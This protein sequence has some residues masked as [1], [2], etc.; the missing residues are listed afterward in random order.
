VPLPTPLAPP[1]QTTA[2]HPKFGKVGSLAELQA[3]RHSLKDVA[4][5]LP[6]IPLFVFWPQARMYVSPSGYLTCWP[7][8]SGHVYGYAV[9]T[10]VTELETEVADP[11]DV[12]ELELVPAIDEVSEELAEL[13]RLEDVVLLVM[14]LELESE[15]DEVSEELAEPVRL[16]EVVLLVMELELE[17]ELEFVG[18]PAEKTTTPPGWGIKN[19]PGDLK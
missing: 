18:G 15:L 8:F 17:L 13:E 6:I 19:S 14:G 11:D 16:E 10:A 4:S 3:A 2:V 7:L 9:F 12:P 1:N 5:E